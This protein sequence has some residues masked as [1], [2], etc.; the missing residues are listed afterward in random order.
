[1]DTHPLHKILQ[2]PTCL[3]TWEQKL[4]FLADK[5]TKYEVISVAQR[6]LLW[7]KETLTPQEREVLQKAYPLVD[8]LEQE[9]FTLAHVTETDVIQYGKEILKGGKHL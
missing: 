9:I 2:T 1:V 4:L 5:M 7:E 3:I 6:F 8:A